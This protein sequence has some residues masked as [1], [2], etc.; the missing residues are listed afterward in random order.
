[1]PKSNNSSF[2]TFVSQYNVHVRRVSKERRRRLRLFLIVILKLTRLSASRSYAAR[3]S[4]LCYL[5]FRKVNEIICLL[6]IL[7][8]FPDLCI[9]VGVGARCGMAHGTQRTAVLA[10]IANIL[11]RHLPQCC[12]P[13]TPS[14][15][16]DGPPVPM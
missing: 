4:A 9:K 5:L 8:A 2:I 14:R 16:A 10:E 13:P 11:P 6:N 1:M 12:P 7:I 3:C 15:F